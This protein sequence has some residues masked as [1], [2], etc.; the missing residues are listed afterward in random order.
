MPPRETC[1]TALPDVSKIVRRHVPFP[2]AWQRSATV[3]VGAAS[4]LG[5]KTAFE[6]RSTDGSTPSCRRWTGTALMAASVQGNVTRPTAPSRR[7]SGHRRSFRS[8]H[9]VALP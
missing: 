9:N 4:S 2:A 5:G 3:A 7:L 6:M 8:P 1:R